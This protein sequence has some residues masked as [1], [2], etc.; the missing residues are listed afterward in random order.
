VK[1]AIRQPTEV[2]AAPDAGL[3]AS[4]DEVAL[5][6]STPLDHAFLFSVYAS[7]REE[8][9]GLTAW[10]SDQKRAF[11][12]MQFAAQDRYYREHFPDAHYDVIEADGEPVGRLYVARGM[13]EIRIVDIAL[14]PAHRGRGIGRALLA[15]LQEEAAYSRCPIVIHVERSDRARRLYTRMGFVPVEESGVHVLMMW[16]PP[17]GESSAPHA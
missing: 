7:S 9:L 10:D 15:A 3:R 17:P 11:L 14:L 6:A 16:M 12:A 13:E 5:R 4:P 1:S 2:V 8:E